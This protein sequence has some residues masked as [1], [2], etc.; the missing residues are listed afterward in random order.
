[1][2]PEEAFIEAIRDAPDDDTPRLIFADWLEERGDPHGEFIRLQCALA[3]LRQGD[4]RRGALATRERALWERHKKVWLGGTDLKAG[5][6]KTFVRGFR[7]WTRFFVNNYPQYDTY[8]ARWAPVQSIMLHPGGGKARDS[9]PEDGKRLGM[10][11]SLAGWL[12]LLAGGGFTAAWLPPLLASPHLRH[13]RELH[14]NRVGLNGDV[15][16]TLAGLP[17][18]ENLRKFSLKLIQVGDQEIAA[19]ADEPL[20]GRLTSLCCSWGNLT[21]AGAQALAASPHLDNLK[22]LDLRGNDAISRET[23]QLLYVRFGN[24]VQF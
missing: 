10:C 8:C 15:V 2:T 16:R 22:D 6:L 19:L 7:F 9:G 17:N 21:D 11:P 24:R 1:M 3:K 5:G 4:P 13:L 20:L 18:L 12:K 14:L 23:R